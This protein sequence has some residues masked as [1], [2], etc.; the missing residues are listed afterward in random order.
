MKAL[1]AALFLAYKLIDPTALTS[2]W[3]PEKA[4]AKHSVALEAGSIY[5][6]R[7]VEFSSTRVHCLSVLE[8]QSDVG[9]QKIL[10]SGCYPAGHVVVLFENDETEIVGGAGRFYTFIV[11]REHTDDPETTVYFRGVVEVHP[12]PKKTPE[13]KAAIA[14]EK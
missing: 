7:K 14:P 9:Q 12:A 13:K 3:Q 2:S 8:V 5:K 6:L 10:S 4:Q 1:S 11:N